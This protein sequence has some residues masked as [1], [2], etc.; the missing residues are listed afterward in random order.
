[1]YIGI[2]D[3]DG[4]ITI[5]N[6]PDLVEL[7]ND[8]LRVYS[9]PRS[10][11]TVVQGDYY[12]REQLIRSDTDYQLDE[13]YEASCDGISCIYIDGDNDNPLARAMMGILWRRAG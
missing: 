12:P 3:T 13:V 10:I 8:K 1:M 2:T 4:A 5:L 11:E 9:Y 6:N 7:N